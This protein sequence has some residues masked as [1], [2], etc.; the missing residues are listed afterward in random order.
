MA[1]EGGTAIVLTYL[2]VSMGVIVAFL[3]AVLMVGWSIGRRRERRGGRREEE[4]PSAKPWRA[5]QGRGSRYG[6]VY[7]SCDSSQAP[8]LGTYL[9]GDDRTGGG[10]YLWHSR[11]VA[12]RVAALPPRHQ[13]AMVA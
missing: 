10:V 6:R 11:E 3:W 12:E 13:S 8:R 1:I 7:G 9:S 4:Q 2:L 5:G